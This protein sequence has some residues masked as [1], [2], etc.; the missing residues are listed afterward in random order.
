[1][2]TLPSTALPITTS[3]G[4]QEIPDPTFHFD[5]DPD[6]KYRYHYDADPGLTFHFDAEIQIRLPIRI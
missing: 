1:M 2:M 6:T 4:E 3:A 5:D